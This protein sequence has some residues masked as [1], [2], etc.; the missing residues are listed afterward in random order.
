LPALRSPG[1]FLMATQES[2]AP[3]SIMR[4][5]VPRAAA[6]HLDLFRQQRVIGCERAHAGNAIA[7]V[8]VTDRDRLSLFSNDRGGVG[9]HDDIAMLAVHRELR[10]ADGA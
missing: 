1:Y 3:P 7:G 6:V 2:P 8:D 9:F 5:M 10:S 4:S